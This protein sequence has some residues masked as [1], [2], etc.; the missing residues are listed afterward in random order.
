MVKLVKVKRNFSDRMYNHKYMQCHYNFLVKILT[1][2][3]AQSTDCSGM[4][5]PWLIYVSP[6][7]E[8]L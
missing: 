5:P 8:L 6:G 7:R 4:P 2:V 3:A 1:T